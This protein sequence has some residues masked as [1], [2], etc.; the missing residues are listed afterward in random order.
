MAETID[1]T[2]S[3]GAAAEILILVLDQGTDEGKAQAREELRRMAKAADRALA[4]SKEYNIL[5][6]MVGDLNQK[7]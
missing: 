1:L 6:A 2:P 4:L 7:G 3:W 5:L